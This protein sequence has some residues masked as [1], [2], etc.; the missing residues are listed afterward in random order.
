MLGIDHE[1]GTGGD[2]LSL[3]QMSAFLESSQDVGFKSK[4][5]REIY[6]FVNHQ[7]LRQQD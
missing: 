5:R 2:K 3:E 6:A 4:G 7:V 1:H